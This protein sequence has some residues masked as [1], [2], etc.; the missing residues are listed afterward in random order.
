[1]GEQLSLDTVKYHYIA[2][3]FKPRAGSEQ[4]LLLF[5]A[6]AGDIQQWAGVP[7][8]AFDY[9]H[10]FQRTLQGPR[11]IEI[12]DFFKQSLRN[13]SPTSVVIGLRRSTITPIGTTDNADSIGVEMV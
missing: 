6:P 11:V 8:K 2:Q 13:V 4:Q 5:A 3:R 9:E 1:M 12:A 7:R 10:G